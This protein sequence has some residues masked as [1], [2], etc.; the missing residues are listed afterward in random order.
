MIRQ[1]GDR[2]QSKKNGGVEPTAP[3]AR[4]SRG[5]EPE[6]QLKRGR[7]EP[8]VAEDRVLRSKLVFAVR[9]PKIESFSINLRF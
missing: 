5:G 2:R 9:V 3:S 7:N 6:K 1:V 8:F 4:E